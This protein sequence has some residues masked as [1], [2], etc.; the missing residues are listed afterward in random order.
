MTLPAELTPT[1]IYLITAVLI[2][3]GMEVEV[4]AYRKQHLIKPLIDFRE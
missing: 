1:P 3:L 2:T 4:M